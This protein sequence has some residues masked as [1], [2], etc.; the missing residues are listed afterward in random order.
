M[1]V[2]N[3]NFVEENRFWGISFGVFFKD[4]QKVKNLVNLDFI[5][6]IKFDQNGAFLA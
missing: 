1:V 6:H 5:F 4:L 3:T 2:W